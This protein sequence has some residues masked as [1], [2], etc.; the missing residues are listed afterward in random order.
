MTWPI[1]HVYIAPLDFQ[2]SERDEVSNG[3]QRDAYRAMPLTVYDSQGDRTSKG[4]PMIFS[5]SGNFL[6]APVLKV[7][8]MAVLF[9]SA[10]PF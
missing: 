9:F 2:A 5:R 4:Q 6:G 3:S 10:L 1:R 7:S 8:L